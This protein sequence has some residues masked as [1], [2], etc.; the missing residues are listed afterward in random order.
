LIKNGKYFVAAQK[1]SDNFKVLFARLA[2]EGAGRP[3]DR[4]GF[5]DGPWTPETLADAISAIDGNE[6]G[7][8]LRAV[9]MWFQD[10]DNG[11]GND[12]IRWLARIFGC[13][14]PHE[15][16]KWQAEIRASKE[17]LATERR[18][19][20]REVSDQAE[21]IVESEDETTPAKE[22]VG[23][24]RLTESVFGGSPLNL[25]S[26]VF[27]G[28]V[29]LGF[30]SYF[31]GI[32]EVTFAAPDG[33]SKQVG[34]LW[35][36]N[37]TFLF[38]AFMPLYFGLVSDLLSFWRNEGRQQLT[39]DS[40]S[41]ESL[42]TWA[43]NVN[44]STYTFWAVLLICLLFAGAF[45]WIGVRLLP[46]IRGGEE[47]AIDWGSLALVR[48]EVV[49]VRAA[50]LFT[51]LAYLY[52]CICF[53][54]FF[55]AFILLHTVAQD[56]GKLQVGLTTQSNVEQR[57]NSE[58]IGLRMIQ[59]IFRCTIL[60]VFVAVCMKLQSAYLIS[61]GSNIL[62]WILGDLASVFDASGKLSKLGDYSAPNHYSSLLIV[63]AAGFVFLYG[64][65]RL[66]KGHRA[67]FVIWIKF[68]TVGLLVVGYLLIGA[69][70]GFSLL[71]IISVALATYG[72]FDPSFGARPTRNLEEEHGVS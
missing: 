58:L 51:G 34:F 35:A 68:V 16:S 11:I 49:S 70:S 55:A 25:P 41:A 7:I 72:L 4:H 5:A 26:S 3:V 37:W 65:F 53:Y 9:Q 47:F 44:A 20:R 17:R 1:S 13:G 23:L 15:T 12:N 29:A 32:H 63:L 60:A 71:L 62:S 56:Y 42:E 14:D 46:L 52:M 43:R 40:N 50:I 54:L 48:P 45:Q 39:E 59:S 21:L 69:F 2:A 27:A 28:S 6:K 38:M 64:S 22:P 8:E 61:S 24:A 31:L 66:D 67:S 57:L 10:N 36:P 33:Q 30:T 18:Q 19:K